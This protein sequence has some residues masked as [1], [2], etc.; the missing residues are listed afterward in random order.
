[1]GI[2]AYECREVIIALGGQIVVDFAPMPK[3]GMDTIAHIAWDTDRPLD[4]MQA[5]KAFE[6]ADREFKEIRNATMALIRQAT[7]TPIIDPP[8]NGGEAADGLEGDL[9]VLDLAAEG[10]PVWSVP[11]ASDQPGDPRLARFLALLPHPPARIV[12]LGTTGVYGNRDGE[13]VDEGSEPRPESART[14]RRLAAERLLVLGSGHGTRRQLDAAMSD[15]GLSY[16]VAAE[17]NVPQVAQALAAAGRGVAVASDD[18][19]Y[20]LHGVRIRPAG[21]QLELR[22][23][24]FGAWD[25]SH[26]AQA[27]IDELVAGLARYT[28]RDDPVAN[29]AAMIDSS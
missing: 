13:R 26:Y 20:G 23:P 2:G 28:R 22:V 11:P 7:V 24:L 5:E 16:G 15:A 9:R 27:V 17:T 29:V 19:R 3:V 4:L 14:E 6:L 21:G 8:D 18:A 25:G 12:Y 1:M 10:G